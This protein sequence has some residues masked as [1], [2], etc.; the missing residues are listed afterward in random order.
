MVEI[1]T[2]K[3]SVSFAK[4]HDG[5]NLLDYFISLEKDNQLVEILDV[6][7]AMDERIEV[8]N[9]VATLATKCLKSNGKRGRQ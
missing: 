8:V 4:N 5:R 2:G 1:L 7:V 6:L 9:Q 3:V